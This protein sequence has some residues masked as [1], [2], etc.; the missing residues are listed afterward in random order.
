MKLTYEHYIDSAH[1]LKDTEWLVTKKCANLHGHTYKI[2]VEIETE[3]MLPNGMIV[4]FSTIKQTLDVLDHKYI[5]DVFAD[6][7]IGYEPTAE[8]ISRY[9]TDKI[10]DSMIQ[11]LST[12]KLRVGVC[13]GWKGKDNFIWN[14]K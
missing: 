14:E 4:D 12:F 13:E 1:Q 6:E 8:N 9:Y 5:N 3:E 10:A 11:D 2:I 7:D